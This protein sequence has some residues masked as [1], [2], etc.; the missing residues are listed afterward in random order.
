M[1]KWAFCGKRIPGRRRASAK[2]LRHGNLV[3]IYLRKS[4]RGHCIWSQAEASQGCHIR[5]FR[6]STVPCITGHH[7][8]CRLML[9]YMSF[10][11]SWLI[12]CTAVEMH[13]TSTHTS[14]HSHGHTWLGLLTRASTCSA[15]LCCALI[16]PRSCSSAGLLHLEA[17]FPISGPADLWTWHGC[18]ACG[19]R[20][21]CWCGPRVYVHMELRML[22]SGCLKQQ[23]TLPPNI[24]QP[25]LG[26]TPFWVVP[27]PLTVLIIQSRTCLLV[28]FSYL[29][30][31]VKMSRTFLHTKIFL[32]STFVVYA[33]YICS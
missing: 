28:C 24:H 15:L 10:W 18:P 31:N 4:Q 23:T 1:G 11:T 9:T 5:V 21:G 17:W 33:N 30:T 20:V 19:C 16:S 26:E 13:P 29:V 2:A 25:C 27:R 22:F 8:H 6:M 3:Y 32:V 7:P 14:L 12:S